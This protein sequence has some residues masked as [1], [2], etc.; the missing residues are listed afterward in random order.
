MLGLIFLIS[1]VALRLKQFAGFL[2]KRYL[3]I[4][5]QGVCTGGRMTRI[6]DAPV[7]ILKSTSSFTVDEV[8]GRMR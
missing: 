8:H 6:D 1:F 4:Q 3:F 5:A 7:T 2:D